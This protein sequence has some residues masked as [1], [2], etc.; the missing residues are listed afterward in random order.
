V[1]HTAIRRNLQE[2][3]P[4]IF[5]EKIADFLQEPIDCVLPFGHYRMSVWYLL[6]FLKLYKFL[7]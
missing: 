2:F 5:G 6:R 1:D 7:S 4:L 3:V